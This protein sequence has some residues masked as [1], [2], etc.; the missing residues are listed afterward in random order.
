MF[1][2]FALKIHEKFKSEVHFRVYAADVKCRQHFQDKKNGGG[3][4]DI[5]KQFRPR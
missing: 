2:F 3:I 5:S 4:R 1:A